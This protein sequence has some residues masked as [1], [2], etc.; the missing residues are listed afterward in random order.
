MT[1]RL[2]LFAATSH[3]EQPFIAEH[4]GTNLATCRYATDRM[5]DK[6][7]KRALLIASSACALFLTATLANAASP[8]R[9]HT[10]A[11]SDVVRVAHDDDDGDHHRYRHARRHSGFAIVLGDGDGERHHRRHYRHH[12][13][14]DDN[15]YRHH[16]H[17]RHHDNDESS[18]IRIRL[19]G[20]HRHHNDE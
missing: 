17:W 9:I 2:Q 15:G 5:E 16:R 18:G 20:R 8:G 13:D 14:D 19:G 11:K 6:I 4:Q 3:H 12:D 10:D 1:K 7:M